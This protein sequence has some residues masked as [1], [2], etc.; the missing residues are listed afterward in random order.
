MTTEPTI[1]DTTSDATSDA[2][3][4]GVFGNP[5]APLAGSAVNDL[6]IDEILA[7]AKTPERT[8]RI[9][10]RADLQAEYDEL[11]TELAGLVD[12][13][14][15]VIADEEAALGETTPAQRAVELEARLRALRDEMAENTWS[16]RF[17][18][19]T[20]DELALFNREHAPKSDDQDMTEY[21]TQLIAACA[22]KPNLT[23]DDVRKLRKALGSRA[24]GELVNA[25]NWVCS[26]GGVDVP[27]SSPFSLSRPGR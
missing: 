13:E 21:N 27:K 2:T 7:R 10:L 5:D 17:R 4:G 6:T 20:T 15:R 12:A 19:L 25:A 1:A 14:G 22:V 3:V 26:R 9:C 11:V 18:G 24:M 8:A 23:V 16:V